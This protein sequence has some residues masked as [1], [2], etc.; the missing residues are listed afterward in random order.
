MEEGRPSFRVQTP[1]K[2]SFTGSR[3]LQDGWVEEPCLLPL[4]CVCSEP[5][6]EKRVR[7]SQKAPSLPLF[8]PGPASQ[9]GLRVWV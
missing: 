9:E 4:P 1:Q 7:I 3:V 8:L 5:T 6:W 2:P